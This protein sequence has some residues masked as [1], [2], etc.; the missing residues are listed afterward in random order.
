MI[1]PS[2]PKPRATLNRREWLASGGLAVLGS[3]AMSPA[4]TH[5]ALATADQPFR[6]SL[7]MGTLRGHELK[8]E[9]EIEVAAQAGY[10]AIE[11]WM[12]RLNRYVQEGGS[13]KALRQ[14]LADLNLTVEDAIGFAGWGADD[15]AQRA[16]GLEQAKKDMDQL[17]QLGA[18]R[19]AA[20]PVGV[21]Q[22]TEPERLAERYRKLLE[23]GDQMGVVPVLEFWGRHP[24]IGKLSTALAI[25]AESG[26]AKAC[27][28][29]DVFHMYRG[30]S[31]FEGLRLL[32]PQALPVLHMNDY[33]AHPPVEKLND[34]HR[35]F[36]GD[37]V[38]PLTE[39]LR[40]IRSSGAAP[41][42]S[43]EVFNPEYYKRDAL[44]VARTGLQ[45]MKDVL[46]KALAFP[47]IR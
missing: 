16:Q 30:G 34:S 27:V 10:D 18:R 4:A 7:N 11:P 19:M 28:L 26:H 33:P 22:K 9:K 5:A 38:A 42:L 47:A 21:N 32:G 24:I 15:D 39:I 20:P 44:E 29:A 13:L 25:A 17:A 1:A 46:A 41:V 12:N 8:L 31:P 40:H 23:L 43:L 36:P 45:K 3:V 37:G 2:D 6:F 14:R 35:V